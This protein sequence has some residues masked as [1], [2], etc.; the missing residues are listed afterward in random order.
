METKSLLIGLGGFILGGLVVSVAATT[1]QKPAPASTGMTM[2]EMTNALKGKNGDDFDKAFITGMIEHHQGA[3]DMARLAQ[4][5]AKHK[6]IKKM[7][8]E[9]VSAQSK[10]IDMMQTWQGDWGYKNV[11]TSHE[12]M[13]R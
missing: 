7:S 10:E 3:I 6:E 1:L 2:T 4:D 8:E 11:P 13:S 9:I 12:M 5:N